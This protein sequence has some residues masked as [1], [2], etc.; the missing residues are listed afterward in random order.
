MPNTVYDMYN[1]CNID[2]TID[3]VKVKWFFSWKKLELEK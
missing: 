1:K 3:N 2:L